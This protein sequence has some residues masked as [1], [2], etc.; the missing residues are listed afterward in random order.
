M[1]QVEDNRRS[2]I[3]EAY[4][5]YDRQLLAYINVRVKNEKEAEDILHD[6][7]L[8]VIESGDTV[9]EVTV[10][11][12]LYTIARN[13][14]IDYVR[15]HTK[16]TEIYDYLYVNSTCETCST[17]ADIDAKSI[18]ESE[19]HCIKMMPRQRRQVYCLSRYEGL[20]TKEIA[21]ELHI[22]SRT[23]EAHLFTGRKFVRNHIK[24]VCGL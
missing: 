5:R 6:T 20:N 19:S 13:L 22:S 10:K 4:S 9:N 24:A 18:M 21:D 14:I 7:F 15:R 3:A 16:R 11:S 17:E 23:V 2:A 1:T 12:Y 8:R